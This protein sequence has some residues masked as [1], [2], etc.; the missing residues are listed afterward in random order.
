MNIK[1]QL[2]EAINEFNINAYKCFRTKCSDGGDWHQAL[3]NQ[4]LM[5]LIEDPSLI[6]ERVEDEI[7]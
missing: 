1:K 3:S 2:E 5:Y 7:R 6:T 4:H